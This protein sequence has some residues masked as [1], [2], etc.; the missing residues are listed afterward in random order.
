MRA[1]GKRPPSMTA[2]FVTVAASLF[3]ALLFPQGAV[4]FELFGHRFFE[5]APDPDISPDAQ[6]YTVAIDTVGADD[7][8]H[9]AVLAASALW[10]G[11]DDTPPPSTAALP[12]PSQCR[13]WPHHRRSLSRGALRR[14]RRDHRQWSRSRR[15]RAGR[16]SAATGE[17]GDA[18]HAWPALSFRQGCDHRCAAFGAGGR[19]LQEVDA[20]RDRSRRR[21]AGAG[22]R[23]HGIGKAADRRLA[24]ARP[25]ARQHRQARHRCPARHINPRRSDYR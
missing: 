23:C 16:R 22:W 1:K 8:L 9:A 24:A 13:I 19:G 12:Q 2:R 21:R 5:A 10:T 7:N 14:H 20:G 17:G 25:S 4:A 6:R 15:D 18:R 3:S 11:R